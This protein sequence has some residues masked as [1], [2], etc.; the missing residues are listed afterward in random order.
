MLVGPVD[1]LVDPDI[2]GKY[3]LHPQSEEKLAELGY[4]CRS[5][6]G[7][8]P[9]CN[10]NEEELQLLELEEGFFEVEDILESHLCKSTSM[11]EYEVRFKGCGTA[12]DMWLPSS[13]NCPIHFKNASKYGRKRRHKVEPEENLEQPL[14][15][16]HKKNTTSDIEKRTKKS[17][18]ENIS[19]R[20]KR[21]QR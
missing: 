13:F 6:S 2:P 18:Q 9:S 7:N 4:I 21:G 1:L 12:E 20:K 5:E 8:G 14:C 19:L 17:K 15:A 16:K 11:Y 10:T 3:S